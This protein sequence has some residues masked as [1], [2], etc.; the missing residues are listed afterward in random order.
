MARKGAAP[1]VRLRLPP[2]PAGEE[3][4]WSANHGHK[5]SGPPL[6][7]EAAQLASFK[8]P[9]EESVPKKTRHPP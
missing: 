2:P 7:K 8:K 1:S 5:R 9:W 4:E 3:F 6:L